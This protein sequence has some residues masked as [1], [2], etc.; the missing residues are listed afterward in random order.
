MAEFQSPYTGK[1]YKGPDLGGDYDF[2]ESGGQASFR[3]PY[4]GKTYALGPSEAEIFRP[5]PVSQPAPEPVPDADPGVQLSDYLKLYLSGSAGLGRSLNRLVELS[6][7]GSLS[8]SLGYDPFKT[9]DRL[10]AD[11]V[12]YWS[13]SLSD[14]MKDELSKEFVRKNEFGEYEWGGAGVT[15]ALG[16]A[17]ES[18]PSVLAS[19]G[20]GA[21]I[22]RVLQTFGNPVGRS[23]LVE[24]AAQ[25]KSSGVPDAANQALK[26]LRLVDRAIGV[27][28]FGAAE[29]LI[30][31]GS[32][33][34]NVYDA[35]QKLP[36]DKLMQ[37]ERYRQVLESTDEA[38]DD[39]QKH[40]YAAE[41]VAK[42]A[43]SV[44]GVQSGLTTALL[45]APMGAFFGSLIGRSNIGRLSETRLRAAL[46]GA[47]GEGAQEA[48]QSGAEQRIFN[49]AL[50]DA[51]DDRDPNE[52][53]VNAM[54]G[55]GIAG[56]GVG[57]V[58]GGGL[59][60]PDDAAAPPRPAAEFTPDQLDA[61][62]RGEPRP[63]LLEGTVSPPEADFVA[64][65]DGVVR[66]PGE[67]PP[68]TRA[69]PA[70]G[71]SGRIVVGPDGQARPEMDAEFRSVQAEMDRRQELGMGRERVAVPAGWQRGEADP[72]GAARPLPRWEER[73]DEKPVARAMRLKAFLKKN[74]DTGP[75]VAPESLPGEPD[76]YFEPAAPGTVDLPFDKLIIDETEHV[77]AEGT[78]KAGDVALKRFRAAAAGRVPKRPAIDVKVMADGRFQVVDGNGTVVALQRLPAAAAARA[79]IVDFEVPDGDDPKKAAALRAYV[80]QLSPEARADLAKQQMEA[81]AFKPKFDAGL[82][83]IAKQIGATT[84]LPGL[85]SKSGWGRIAEKTVADNGGDAAKLKDFVRGTIVVETPEQAQAAMDAVLAKFGQAPKTSI[86]Q[87][88]LLEN[89]QQLLAADESGYA[90]IKINVQ[91]D[92]GRVYEVQISTEAMLKAKD[93]GHKFYEDARSIDSAVMTRLGIAEGDMS[94]EE[95]RAAINKGMTKAEKN[96]R[97]AL[98]ASS[99]GAYLPS[100][101][102]FRAASN[103]ASK[104]ASVISTPSSSTEKAGTAF[105][106]EPAKK[107]AAPREP[108]SS[109]AT[110]PSTNQ[111]VVAGAP[112]SVLPSISSSPPRVQSTAPASAESSGR[113]RV[114]TP[115]GTEVEVEPIVVEADDLLTS[116]REGYPQELQPRQRGARAASSA[117]V[118][119]MAATL[120]PERLG[121]SVEAELGAPVVSQGLEVESGNGRVMA[122]RKA[123]ADYPERAEAYREFIKAQGFDVDGM[124]APVLV[125]RR[126]TDLD[127][128]ARRQFTVDANKST[129]M[130]LSAAEQAN[131]DAALLDDALLSRLV[132]GVQLT[133]GV[134]AGFVRGFMGKLT[135]GEMNELVG[136]DGT[137]SQDGVRRIQ[138]ALLAKAYGGAEESNAMLARSMESPDDNVRSITGAL[139]DAAPQFAQLRQDVADGVLDPEYALTDDLLASIEI[140]S[141]MRESG[142][143]VE[144][145]LRQGDAFG[146][147]TPRRESII[148]LF[149]NRALTA[150]AS[151]EKIA[152][153]LKFYAAGAEQQRNNQASLVDST[154]S[155]DELLRG[156]LDYVQPQQ[157]AA[158]Q[159][160]IFAAYSRA[161]MRDVRRAAR[162]T[163]GTAAVRAALE[164]AIAEVSSL[165]DVRVVDSVDDLAPEIGLVPSDIEGAYLMDGKTVII[166][167]GNLTVERAQRVFLHEVFGHLAMER[168]P[169]MAK[170]IDMVRTLHGM[171]NKSVVAAW[172]TVARTQPNLSGVEH[173]KETI[174]VLAESGVKN[175]VIDRLIAAVRDMIRRMGIQLPL[176]DGD[177][178]TLIARAA[179]DLL[180]DAKAGMTGP[181]E[182][183]SA[184]SSDKQIL[185]ALA[186]MP[187]GPMLDAKTYVENEL[188]GLRKAY[189]PG[190]D[191]A[192]PREIEQRMEQLE[193]AL[194]SRDAFGSWLDVQ[195]DLEGRGGLERARDSFAWSMPNL[196]AEERDARLKEWFGNSKIVDA[197]GKPLRVY[198]GTTHDFSEFNPQVGSKD[199]HY[200]QALYFTSNPGD[201]SD[202]YAGIG[203]DMQAKIE[204]EA[205]NLDTE[206]QDAGE[207]APPRWGTPE[208]DARMNE[209]REKAMKRL[210]GQNRGA[211]YPVYLKIENPVTVTPGAGTEFDDADGSGRKLRN[212]LAKTIRE[213]G[214]EGADSQDFAAQVSDL[215]EEGG[216]LT[217]STIEMVY[218]KSRLFDVLLDNDGATNFIRDLWKN[219]GFD[220]IILNA[221]ATFPGMVSPG[222]MHFHAFKPTQVKSATGNQGTYRRR[223]PNILFSRAAPASD[224]LQAAMDR[225]MAQAP[226][227]MTMRDKARE[228]W[229]K[230]RNVEALEVKQGLI[231][232]FA[233]L[234]ALERSGNDGDLKDASQSAYKAALS[235]K[236]LAS[237]MSAVMLR[238][239]P[240]YQNG[241]FQPGKDRKGLIDIF[242]PL[243]T[244]PDGNLL[245]QWEFFAATNR[246]RR[247]K[248]EKNRDGTSRE[249]LFT[250]ADIQL[251][252]ELEQKYPE[253][254]QI[255][256]DWQAF[257]KQTLD[258]AQEAG[259]I[260][261]ASRA[262][263]EQNDY[264]P[265]YRAMEDAKE[266]PR[267]EAQLANQRAQ[268]KR[269][270][271]SETQLGNVFENMVMNTAHLID[272]SYKNRAMQKVVEIADG[273]AMNKVELPWEAVKFSNADLARALRAA[274]LLVGNVDDDG[275]AISKM[276][277]EQRESWSTL[278]RK[279]APRGA[280][281]VTVMVAGKPVYYEVTDPLVLRSIA[282]LGTDTFDGMVT[283][284]FRGSKRL[285]TGAITADPAFMLANFVRDTL[286][287]WVVSDASMRPVVDAVIGLKATWAED[288]TLMQLMMSGAGGGG[289]YDSAPE[290]IRKLVAERVPAGKVNGFMKSVVSPKNAWRVWRKIGASAENAN[291]VAVFKAVLAAGGSVA[292]AAYQA[293]DVLNFS[294]R[295][296]YAAMRWL[297]ETVPFMNARVQGL[298]RLY[299]GARDNRQAFMIKGSMILAA[300]MA[301]ALSNQDNPEY[302]EL[303]EWDKD[304][305]WHF[306]VGGEHFRLPKPF[307]VG[308]IF[309]TIPERAWRGLSG[310]DSGKLV[311]DRLFA[312]VADTFAFNP[313]P[314]FVKPII[315]QY[316]NRSFFTGSPIV[317][318]AEQNL[319]PEAQFTPWT[320]ETMRELAKAMPDWAP[321]WI[322]SPRRLEA[323]VRG[324]LGSMGMYVVGISDHVTREALSYPESPGRRIY[325]YPVVSRF[326]R[327]PNPRVTKYA[328]Q[329]YQM[330]NE[331]NAVYS[332]INR[333]RRE[334]RFDD[335]KALFEENKGKLAVRARL[336]RLATQVRKTNEQIRIIQSSRTMPADQ[337]REKIDAL[338]AR[339]NEITRQVAPFADLF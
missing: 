324:Y 167:A 313:T 163:T 219:A 290:D 191:T 14:G 73:D 278:F 235:T 90:D 39:M 276:T 124:R 336:N 333:F 289:Y 312:M 110:S 335:A 113:T 176:N 44:A 59:W 298:Y 294:M 84:K 22:T 148:R 288:E 190:R 200:G 266:G 280:N 233:S 262:L 198:H 72:I 245:R 242:R 87:N 13:D 98:I 18:A 51:G 103:R 300:T 337:K 53:V 75:A 85:K 145:T 4:S 182:G 279:V 69:L 332:T 272:A 140:I 334:Q 303:P 162:P 66:R 218:R 305:Y 31:G 94:K 40:A 292:E 232:G 216:G 93:V 23:V 104:S 259:V 249:K 32:A 62:A 100:F 265:F 194:E 307:E 315:E 185:D 199:G 151:R 310:R 271:G 327:D 181:L 95:V 37:N 285:L 238:G 158:R 79:R 227:S 117:Q 6:P 43:A 36:P 261:P 177:V 301:L 206:L 86:R 123:F 115:T 33:N 1:W 102:A 213:Y 331:A 112:E 80:K 52:G 241:A 138:G 56:A 180:A 217:A 212:A 58:L 211:V 159:A 314:Q 222:T 16:M 204:R 169:D 133:A 63:L 137:L 142:R 152:A 214:V 330:L 284:L 316:A 255:L 251:G 267:T 187:S 41:V 54:V 99:Q 179:R 34:V 172:N 67:T 243:T 247:L 329:M 107:R 264:V 295:G 109:M 317:G 239:V 184:L 203:P 302:E 223:S 38:M 189:P 228:A 170:A 141:K 165:V 3:S 164:P 154:V 57:G 42:E 282:G 106:P 149:Y 77:N 55:G 9:V 321:E 286:S 260:D 7:L 161:G 156:A 155:P 70:P 202:N 246:A 21:G 195:G 111:K 196:S 201:A 121:F 92:N 131:A 83:E 325:D 257:N 50:I 186:K 237:V 248:T 60:S 76:N 25:L 128:D 311:W 274:G 30:S 188:A 256:D 134:N 12:D 26:K 183:L 126:K 127:A 122:I 306:F 96:K 166:V 116:D 308:A 71:P 322:R 253:F 193:A 229:Q 135:T 220:G 129:T 225:T 130:K 97:G 175:S 64:G 108:L 10:A 49:R 296:D 208:Y 173:A 326:A 269:L 215:L 250:D 48:L 46:T 146:G 234:E 210:L 147:V 160:S 304:M 323:A 192:P 236:N 297:T 231:D 119:T 178:R 287:N 281:I 29:G 339:K 88:M 207:E 293:R 275:A 65:A 78:Q 28:A 47:A 15:T 252:R 91:G 226:E 132:P 120:D 45:G 258:L 35:V 270:S 136:A 114:K 221:K 168:S 8:K 81:Q 11:A 224:E 89:E 209:L 240:V 277:K 319:Q 143:G 2:Q 318:M 153:E 5:R 320:S 150:A 254:R 197:N 105:Q 61:V 338:I 101:R 309:A 230:F 299:R 74:I 205:E 268:I 157:R 244:H 144:E 19:A 174:A 328:D 82:D 263:W 118:Q 68:E 139:L 125:R 24:R 283:Q 17:A 27:A 291:R 171:K 273:V 20:I